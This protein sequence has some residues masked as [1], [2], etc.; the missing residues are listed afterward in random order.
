MIC[1]L[2]PRMCAAERADLSGAG[3][4][5]MGALPKLARAA[6]HLWEEPCIS[7]TRGSGAVFF[8]GCTLRCAYCQN[9]PISHEG[10][11]SQVSVRRLAD[12]FR[13]LVD[14]GA[15]NIN[16]VTGTQFT[17]AILDALDLYRPPVPVVW[18]SGGYERVET[19]RMLKGAVD[20]YLPDLKHI[21]ARL[22][23]LCAG[24][25]DYFA[26][27][28][29]AIKEMCAQTGTPVYDGDGLMLRGTLIR[30]LI[31]P[32][33][34]VEAARVLDFIHDELPTGTPV[35]LMR[36][37]APMPSCKVKGLDR[38]V[39]DKEYARVLDHMLA[40]GLPGYTQEKDSA[41]RAFTPAFD[42]TG[43]DE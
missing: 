7:G 12:I 34:T 29:P 38:R 20:V 5:K 28:G 22:S 2:C 42:G 1:T 10:A 39:T 16:L 35:S 23:A 31:L 14:Q 41:T 27:A 8:S 21:S 19:L 3:F 26:F 33:C 25:P 6:L 43:V 9:A 18:N 37:Y 24:A 11:G 13:A 30:H 4:C 40:L 32:G 15:H 17:P 36:Q